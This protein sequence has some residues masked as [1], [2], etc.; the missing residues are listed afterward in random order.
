M[1]FMEKRSIKN[2]IKSIKFK[3]TKSINNLLNLKRKD[4]V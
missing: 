1:I 4:E 3:S 2:L